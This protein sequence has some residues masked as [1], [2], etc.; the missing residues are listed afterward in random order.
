MK[1]LRS[2][3]VVSVVASRAGIGRERRAIAKLNEDI[4]WLNRDRAFLRRSAYGG[5]RR[6]WRRR[7]FRG[8][9]I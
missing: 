4:A 1:Q 8:R 5:R 7:V 2:V 9:R 3:A 6:L